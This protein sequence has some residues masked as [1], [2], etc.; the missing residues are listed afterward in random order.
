M[1]GLGEILICELQRVF[2]S[3]MVEEALDAKACFLT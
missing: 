2:P 3:F 1:N